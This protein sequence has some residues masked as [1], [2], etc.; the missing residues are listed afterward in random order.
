MPGMDH[1]GMAMVWNW[2]YDTVVVFDFW[3][4]DGPISILVSSA[5]VAVLACMFEAFRAFRTVQDRRL[6]ALDNGDR[7]PGE[8]G[9]DDSDSLL[10]PG[11]GNSP[12]RRRNRGTARRAGPRKSY[13][14]YRAALHGVELFWGYFL[15]MAFM[16]LNG[17]LCLALVGG[18]SVGFYM[19]HG[20]QPVAA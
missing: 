9:E 10:A 18:A 8:E 15:M 13:Q 17:F 2:S 14:M 12:E 11:A 6:L 19:F 20:R 1:G 5:A 4:S 7:D 16:T 3:R